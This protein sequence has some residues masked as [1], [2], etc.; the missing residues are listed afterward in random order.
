MTEKM[1]YFIFLTLSAALIVTLIS[2]LYEKNAKSFCVKCSY[3]IC[4]MFIKS[5]IKFATY[6]LLYM[7]TTIQEGTGSG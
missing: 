6:A 4:R 7:R 3:N 1:D 2:R 5:G